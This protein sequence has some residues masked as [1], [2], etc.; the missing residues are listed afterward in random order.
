MR[1]IAA[2]LLLGCL[3][4]A[5][6]SVSYAK[7]GKVK[8]EPAATTTSTSTAPA[9]ITAS[10]IK[11][12]LSY[13]QCVQKAQEIMNKLNLEVEDSGDGVIRG[14]GAVSVA[15]I[16]CHNVKESVEEKVYI[17]IAVASENDDAADTIMKYLYNYLRSSHDSQP[18]TPQQ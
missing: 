12:S 9:L 17:Q 6:Y 4:L 13:L 8:T 16:N 18:A 2:K 1:T 5:P 10:F 15:V 14:T 3:I 11:P 7:G